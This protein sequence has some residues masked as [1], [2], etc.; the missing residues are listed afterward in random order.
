[1]FLLRANEWTVVSLITIGN[2][3]GGV[4]NEPLY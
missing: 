4:N 2:S 3:I 1:M